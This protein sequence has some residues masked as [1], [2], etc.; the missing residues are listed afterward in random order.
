MSS[1]GQA[2]SDVEES[3][4]L[5]RAVHPSQ[6]LDEEDRPSSAAFSDAELS[7]YRENIW[8]LSICRTVWGAEYGFARFPAAAAIKHGFPVVADPIGTDR[9]PY[10]TTPSHDYCPAHAN[11]LGPKKKKRRLVDDAE[12]ACRPQAGTE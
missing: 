2:I 4:Q 6:W 12:V 5:L 11:V 3:E 9:L 7:V 8:S 10:D 1:A